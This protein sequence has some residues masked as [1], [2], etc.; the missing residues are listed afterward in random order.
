MTKYLINDEVVSKEEFYERLE[1]EVNDYV[2]NNY[3]DILDECYP[4][5]KMGC[6]EFYPSQI[7]KECDPIAYRCGISD[8]QSYRLEDANDELDRYGEF[9]VNGVQ[10]NIEEE[11]EEDEE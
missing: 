2:D 9:I 7:M 11:D 10:F 4:T 8:E 3:D 5:Y 1:E 6:C